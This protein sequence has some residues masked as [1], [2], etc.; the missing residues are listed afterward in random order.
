MTKPLF[1]VKPLTFLTV[2]F[3]SM[4]M[5]LPAGA[6][7]KHV[8]TEDTLTEVKIGTI[9]T[10]YASPELAEEL[11]PE[12]LLAYYAESTQDDKDTK[13]F[14]HVVADTYA[15]S[16]LDEYNENKF[17]GD[18]EK[19]LSLVKSKYREYRSGHDQPLMILLQDEN[20]KFNLYASFPVEEG[21]EPK[22]ATEHIELELLEDASD[23]NTA[24]EILIDQDIES[25]EDK[26]MSLWAI[27]ALSLAIGILV[28][29]ALIW[30]LGR[31]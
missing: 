5:A 30:F 31:V 7:V 4:L 20:D 18:D 10:M 28:I 1:I 11:D 17:S 29:S 14:P 22:G 13:A 2:L 24:V 9:S 8:K 23:V 16:D 3:F 21:K 19:L 12:R 27:I 15:Q 6:A 26:E 25:N